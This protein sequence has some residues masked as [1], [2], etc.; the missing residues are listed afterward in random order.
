MNHATMRASERGEFF[1]L[2]QNEIL[3]FANMGAEIALRRDE[4]FNFAV[5]VARR[6]QLGLFVLY[7]DGDPIT[8]MARDVRNKRFN[9]GGMWQ[10]LP[11]YSVIEWRRNNV[12]KVA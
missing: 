8:T 4:V 1:G 10:D 5:I 3:L 12:P 6:G 2:N 9:V 11:V 7:V